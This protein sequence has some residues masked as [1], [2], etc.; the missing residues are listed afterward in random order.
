MSRVLVRDGA[1][2]LSRTQQVCLITLRTLIGWHFLYEG[3]YKWAL[4]GWSAAGQPVAGWSAAGYLAAATGPLAGLFHWLGSSALVGYVDGLVVGALIVAGLSLMLGLF[5]QLGAWLAIALLSMF[6]LA[7]IPLAGQPVPGAEGA[8]LLVNKTLI[9]WSAVLA[10]LAFHTGRI[11]GL[12]LLRARTAG[13]V[14]AAP[15]GEVA[16]TAAAHITETIHGSHS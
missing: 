13:R 6:Y 2:P 16:P 15:A 4:P 5:T 1:H 7:Q 3:Y 12:D 14:D 8:Y 9:E 11:A 10:V